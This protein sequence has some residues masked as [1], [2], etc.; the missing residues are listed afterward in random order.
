MPCLLP[1]LTQKIDCDQFP[2]GRV[3]ARTGQEQEVPGK[4]GI[5]QL[6]GFGAFLKG[7]KGM[8]GAVT[9]LIAVGEE[10]ACLA[11][12]YGKKAGPELSSSSQRNQPSQAPRGIPELK[13]PSRDLS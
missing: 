7:I 2:C 12:E 3:R 4:A 10:R 6:A 1:Q 5:F 8:A 9:K 13:P 11:S